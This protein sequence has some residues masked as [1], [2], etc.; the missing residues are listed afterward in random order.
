MINLYLTIPGF[1]TPAPG[2]PND[3]HRFIGAPSASP[4]PGAS[5]PP[6]LNARFPYDQFS[7]GVFISELI[8]VVFFI[9][10][11]LTVFWMSWGIYQ[12]IFAG[13][14]KESLAKARAR[15]TWALVGLLLLGLML[16]VSQYVQG[17]FPQNIINNPTQITAPT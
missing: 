13:G 6:G 11:F 5:A 2:D 10:G 17:I 14:N 9:T 15:I 12:Y 16:L 1:P 7:L 3:P 8:P 4:F